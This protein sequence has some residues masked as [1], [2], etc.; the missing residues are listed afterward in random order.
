M[1]KKYLIIDAYI[2]NACKGIGDRRVKNEVKD[3]L[4]SH[5]LEIYERNIALGLSDEDAQKDAISHM[6]DS[7]AI[8]KTFKQIYPVSSFEYFKSAGK[9]FAIPLVLSI[10]NCASYRGI[11]S[12]L[13][14]SVFLLSALNR[15]KNI[16]KTIHTAYIISYINLIMQVVFFIVRHVFVIDES[17]IIAVSLILNLMIILTYIYTISGLV[18]V[19]KQLNEP[20][21]YSGLGILS[22]F[23]LIL[24]F[25]IIHFMQII[26]RGNLGISLL[27][28]AIS[29]LP[30]GLIYTIVTEDIDK[31]ET[32]VPQ[33]KKHTVKKII[34][35]IFVGVIIIVSLN[36][37]RIFTIHQPID[38]V[39]DDTQTNASE[40]RNNLIELGL[41][42]RIADELP[43]SEIL[44]YSSATNLQI[45][46]LPEDT[47][48][49][50]TDSYYTTYFFTLNEEAD[51]L[52]I[53]TLMVI[54]RFEDF[55]KNS[56]TEFFIDYY[57]YDSSEIFCKMLCDT[58]GVTKELTPLKSEPISDDDF[59]EFH[60]IFPSAKD[61]ENH[62]AYIGMT[63]T[64][65]PSTDEEEF[66]FQHY[67]AQ[68][69][70]SEIN[71]PYESYWLRTDDYLYG[72]IINPNYVESEQASTYGTVFQDIL[73]SV[74]NNETID[75]S[76]LESAM[77]DE[78][79]Q[80][81][82]SELLEDIVNQITDEIDNP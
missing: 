74:S 65:I 18:K 24:S 21:S 3:E 9:I 62:R 57:R 81:I 53:R 60:Y 10:I 11:D 38:Y 64:I 43:E 22:I 5:L 58:D 70:L 73:N 27:A 17:L 33:E 1:K 76:E 55:N 63:I 26:D 2:E 77:E 50:F 46:S 31:L 29:L 71:D 75:L 61:G 56:Y 39:V 66:H 13:G 25:A 48:E 42:E 20:K 15:I 45:D 23:A 8:S 82:D 52:K 68:T 72:E 28:G 12:F 32:G 49:D 69:S 40:I 67:Y 80:D 47:A 79:G 16:N 35:S 36:L 54:D 59:K 51:S 78:L 6:G 14:L 4:L 19:R 30:A 37:P 34:L 44:K 7:N 41:P